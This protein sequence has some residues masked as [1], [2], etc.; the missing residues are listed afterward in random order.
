MILVGNKCDLVEERAVTRDQGAAMAKS[1][2]GCSF[3]ESSAKSRV[4]V[5]E[6][7]DCLDVLDWFRYLASEACNRKTNVVPQI[8]IDL[9]RQ[10]TK[11]S[12]ARKQQR[13]KQMGCSLL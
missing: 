13:K 10:V 12:P 7:R 5:A 9:V 3:L 4:N 6:V 1:W 8:F 2:N 11:S